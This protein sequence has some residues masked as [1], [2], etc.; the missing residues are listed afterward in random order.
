MKKFIKNIILILIPLSLVFIIAFFAAFVL[1]AIKYMFALHVILYSHLINIKINTSKLFELDIFDKYPNLFMALY[2]VICII[3]C[4][5]WNKKLNKSNVL[6]KRSLKIKDFFMLFTIGVGIGFISD[7]IIYTFY[8]FNN[9]IFNKYTDHMNS[10][11]SGNLITYFVVIFLAP[12]AEELL[13]RGIIF[14]KAKNAMPFF[15]ANFVQAFL[16]AL[17][18]MN[19]IQMTY[20]FISGLVFGFVMNQYNT[21]YAPIILHIYFNA[22]GSI[23]GYV[24]IN[25]PP[26]M[27]Y[28]LAIISI[29]LIIVIL[30]R[31]RRN[32]SPIGGFSNYIDES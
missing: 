30:N 9:E 13:F 16:F 23:M 11:K 29:P 14:I 1:I 8:Y 18:H 28:I 27:Y 5:I 24:N 2:E 20:T 26:I 19:I 7:S 4:F 22:I 3:V 21:I 12:I 6:L 10:M 15:I 32:Y 25:I 31:V 17:L